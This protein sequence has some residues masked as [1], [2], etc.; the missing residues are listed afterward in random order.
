MTKADPINGTRVALLFERPS[1]SVKGLPLSAPFAMGKIALLGLVENMARELPKKTDVA[2]INISDAILKPGRT[3]L[4]DKPRSM[5]RLGT[6]RHLIEYDRSASQTRSTFQ[7]RREM[8][9]TVR[10]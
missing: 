7:P 10:H 3:K 2:W 4:N 9:W 6:Y 8:S 5:L 1:A